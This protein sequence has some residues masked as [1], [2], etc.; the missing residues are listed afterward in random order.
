MI[1]VIV[2]A[3]YWENTIWRYCRSQKPRATT[4]TPPVSSTTQWDQR[5]PTKLSNCVSQLSS[6]C[7]TG[8]HH[9]TAIRRATPIVTTP[10][11]STHPHSH[12]L[13]GGSSTSLI[14]QCSPVD[15][16]H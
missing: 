15:H 9:N 4:P 2:R 7:V 1:A 13:A 11:V 6:S 16:I 12:G 8:G 3:T 14:T 5:L 10:A